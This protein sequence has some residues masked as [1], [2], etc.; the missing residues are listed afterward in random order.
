MNELD[1]I[2]ISEIPAFF[3]GFGEMYLGEHDVLGRVYIKRCRMNERDEEF[4]V[5]RWDEG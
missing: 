5:R 3:G 1:F 2:I 4:G